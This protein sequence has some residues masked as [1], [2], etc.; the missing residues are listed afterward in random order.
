MTS[1]KYILS[2]VK[3]GFSLNLNNNELSRKS[4][5]YPKTCA[6]SKILG[7]EIQELLLKEI[8]IKTDIKIDDYFSN[9]F[10]RKK[11]NATYRTILKHFKREPIKNA[12]HMIK[13]D[14][15]LASLGIKD[16]YYSVPVCN[17]YRKFLE[18]MDKGETLQSNAMRNGYNY[19]TMWLL[20][21][22]LNPVTV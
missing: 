15:F 3:N 13:P 6:E 2:I 14:M 18:F 1:D 19:I 17:V 16:T 7:T 22:I 10:T 12:I 4:F 8:V 21:K 9:L 20:N 5:E 11:R